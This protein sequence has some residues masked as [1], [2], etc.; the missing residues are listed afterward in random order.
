M[1][2]A[3]APVNGK[4]VFAWSPAPHPAD[5]RCGVPPVASRMSGS[6]WG[7]DSASESANAAKKS[8][9][10]SPSV[11]CTEYEGQLPAR[12][13]EDG[14]VVR[15]VRHLAEDWVQDFRPV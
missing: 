12:G 10:P 11:R 8:T 4:S 6:Y 9:G 7:G 15:R 1:P 3:L 5:G 13:R 2:S 14:A